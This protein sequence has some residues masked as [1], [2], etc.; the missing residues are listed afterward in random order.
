MKL[1]EEI[2]RIK[3]M[4]GLLIESEIETIYDSSVLDKYLGGNEGL[5]DIYKE[6][7][8]TLNDKF[9]EQNFEDEIN[10]S[11]GIKEYN[12]KYDETAI[13]KFNDMIKDNKLD[14][15]VTIKKISLR[16]YEKQKDLF[17]RIAKKRG[18]KIKNGLKQVALPGFSQ[19][20]TGKGFDITNPQKLSDSTLK[21]YGF[22]RPYPKNTN[23]RISEPWHIYYEG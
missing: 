12:G 2:F 6:I 22:I 5:I 15:S 4:M 13:Q 11:G 17:I 16:S 1:Q 14:N 7:E 9:T 3:L 8:K 18:G 23:F 10:Y 19:H 21:K 20:H